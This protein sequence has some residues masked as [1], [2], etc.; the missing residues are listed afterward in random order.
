MIDTAGLV[1][2]QAASDVLILLVSLPGLLLPAPAT[3]AQSSGARRA[4]ASLDSLVGVR[5]SHTRD[6][7]PW[8]G[9]IMRSVS[10]RMLGDEAVLSPFT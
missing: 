10:R 9:L 8:R 2:A 3:S 7:C 5:P 6:V 4:Q 1:G